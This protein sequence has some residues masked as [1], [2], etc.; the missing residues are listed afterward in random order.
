M[1]FFFF[2]SELYCVES[3]QNLTALL[4]NSLSNEGK[5]IGYAWYARKRCGTDYAER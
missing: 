1:N 4:K 5:L 3:I 2:F